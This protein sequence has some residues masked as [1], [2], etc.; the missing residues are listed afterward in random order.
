M[1]YYQIIANRIF[2]LCRARGFSIN[3]LAIMSDLNQSTIDNIMRGVSKNPRIQTLY[4]IALTFNMTV[5]EFLDFPE[6]NTV[7]FVDD[8]SSEELA[9]LKDCDSRNKSKSYPLKY[10]RG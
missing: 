2:S 6:L 1:E 4:K 3:K 9:K 10:L 7:S 5:A 8:I